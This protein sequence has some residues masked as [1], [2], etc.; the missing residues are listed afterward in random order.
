[1]KFIHLSD[2]HIGKSVKDFS[3]IEDQRFILNQI[4]NI[5]IKEK[6]DAVLISGDVYDRTIPSEEAVRLFDDFIY[7]LSEI[8]TKILLISG[9]HDSDERLNFGSRLF[10]NKGVY[11]CTKYNGSLYKQTFEDEYGPINFYLL[12]FVKASQIK[13]FYPESD[14]E[15]YDQAVRVALNNADINITERNVILAH[16]FVAGKSEE[17]ML[18]GSESPAV[19][20]VGLVERIGY[21]CFNDFDYVALGHIHKAQKI[22]REEV[23]YAGTPLKYHVDEVND[24]KSIPIVSMGDKGDVSIELKTLKPLHDM[25]AIKGTM[26]QL[27]DEKNVVNPDDYIFV[28]L[29]DE[30]VINDAM[31]IFRQTYPNTMQ[32]RYENSHTKEIEMVDP[33]KITEMRSFPELISDF[34]YQMYQIDISDEEMAIMNQVARKVGI[35]DETN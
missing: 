13:H 33:S 5:V 14:I 4:I 27:L 9:N 25:R 6:V 23:R 21:D 3:M 7:K 16:Q 1:M 30:D 2:L 11:F 17:I 10:V 32:I 29:T 34:Y 35:I 31:T 18:G 15:T 12:P 28:T 24:E 8:P 19:A 26:K 22:G 20:N